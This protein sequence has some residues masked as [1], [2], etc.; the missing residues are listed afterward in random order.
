M[1][2]IDVLRA[3][4]D[5]N[6]LAGFDVLARHPPAGAAIAPRRFGTVVAYANGRRYGF[7]NPVVILTPTTAGPIEAAVAWVRELGLRVTLRVREDVDDEAVHAAAEAL[8]L[9][10]DPWVER[11]MVQHPLGVAPDLPPGLQIETAT[12]ATLERWHRATAVGF[13]LQ[14]TAPD[15]PGDLIPEGVASDP[16]VR[17]FGGFLDDEPV[18]SSLAIRS[19][20]VVGVYSVGTMQAVRRR[21]IGAAMAWAA[22]EAGRE[23]GCE[24]AV[25]QASEMGEPVYRAMGFQTVAGY[26]T[27]ASRRLDTA[28]TDAG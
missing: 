6:L 26:V 22:V 10:R 15:L 19:E 2:D 11:G 8:G 27:Y 3:W 9:D 4:S 5:E 20:H 28:P 16:D 21:G 25:L 14:D 24:A 12:P 17:L 23:W 7:F 18:A 1:T 13:G